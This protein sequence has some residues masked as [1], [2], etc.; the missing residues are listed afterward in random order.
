MSTGHLDAAEAAARATPKADPGPVASL[1]RGLF[2]SSDSWPQFHGGGPNAGVALRHTAPALQ[3]VWRRDIGD[4]LAS[5]PVVD[6]QGFIYVGTANGRVRRVTPDGSATRSVDLGQPIYAPVAVAGDGSVYAVTHRNLDVD[7]EEVMSFRS[8]LVKLDSSL[9]EKWSVD[10][11]EEMVTLA[12]P[13]LWEPEGGEAFVFLHVGNPFVN[14]LLVFDASGGRRTSSGPRRCTRPIEGGT[15]IFGF[16][17]AVW[18][19]MW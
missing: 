14:E 8:T 16:L 13:K 10:L 15:G 3:P 1:A 4:V 19:A 5:S 17:D 12:A 7:T 6:E 11:P 9:A 2:G 18:D